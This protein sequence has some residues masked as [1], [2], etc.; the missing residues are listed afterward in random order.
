MI[1]LGVVNLAAVSRVYGEGENKSE[2]ILSIVILQVALITL[3]DL[4]CSYQQL[5]AIA[6]SLLI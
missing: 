6:D 2:I 1:F 4:Q 5:R 3:A